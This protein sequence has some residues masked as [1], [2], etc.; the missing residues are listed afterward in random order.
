MFFIEL[1]INRDMNKNMNKIYRNFA[2]FD[3]S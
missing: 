2:G 3:N 1:F